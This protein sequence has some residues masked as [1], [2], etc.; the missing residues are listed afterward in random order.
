M[1]KESKFL[2]DLEFNKYSEY[3]NTPTTI[4]E[5]TK[6]SYDLALEKGWYSPPK[7]TVETLALSIC[8]LTEAIEEFR[9]EKPS[10]YEVNGKPEGLQVEVADCLL[11]LFDMAGRHGWN[12]QTVLEKKHA[13]NKTRVNRHGKKL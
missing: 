5:W 8:E 2:S 13:Y 9:A 1:S 10:Y 4:M 12:L 3:E 11:R 6:V 7:S